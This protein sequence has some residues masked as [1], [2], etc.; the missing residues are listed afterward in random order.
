MEK[1]ADRL[2][3]VKVAYYLN[4]LRDGAGMINR[5]CGFARQLSEAGAS[6]SIISHFRPTKKSPSDQIPVYTV[7]P[8]RYRGLFYHK[9]MFFPLTVLRLLWLFLRIRPDIVLVD[10]HWEAFWALFLRKV[11]RYRVV[12]TYHGVANSK[13]YPGAEGAKLDEIRAFTHRLLP[14]ADEVVVVSDFMQEEIKK[15]PVKATTIHNGVEGS[16]LLKGEEIAA[17]CSRIPTALFVGRFTEYK[18][19]L[20]IVQAFKLVLDVLPDAQLHMYGFFESKAYEKEIRDFVEGNRLQGRILLNKEVP[21]ERIPELLGASR[22]FVNGSVDET[23]CM[24]LLEA[25]A[26]GV[27]CVAF[28]CGGIPEVVIDGKTGL[29]AGEGNLQMFAEHLVRLLS[30]N[31]IHDRFARNA[32]QHARTFS[33][34]VLADQLMVLIERTLSTR[35]RA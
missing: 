15:I 9:W 28:A 20:N 2:T 25:Q 12:F 3:G 4:I 7:W 5:E 11:F 13:F 1:Q 34:S 8:T 19:A 17:V 35:R 22:V 30:D 27:P 18:G 32:L 26:R 24:P 33:Y 6:V 10:L 29:L 16:L 14:R 31:E 21:G 23:F